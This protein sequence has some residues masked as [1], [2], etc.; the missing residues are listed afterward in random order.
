MT[1]G[2]NKLIAMLLIAFICGGH[3]RQIR[4]NRYETQVEDDNPIT[5][6]ATVREIK[7]TP[8]P[9]AGYRPGRAFDLPGEN[10]DSAGI[11]TTTADGLADDDGSGLAT[12]TTETAIDLS[13]TT[14]TVDLE[15]VTLYNGVPLE[16][17][18]DDDNEVIV[19]KK[20]PYPAAGFKPKIAFNLPTENQVVEEEVVIPAELPIPKKAPYPAAGYR[21]S[22]AF[23]L[24]TEVTAESQVDASNKGHPVCGVSTNPLA[25]KPAEGTEE[26]PDSET[27]VVTADV[28]PV[29]ITAPVPRIIPVNVNNAVQIRSQPIM[30]QPLVIGRPFAY[31]A[32]W[33]TW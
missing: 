33:Q 14:S 11:T 12:T 9:A 21:P 6:N 18:N 7:P 30:A 16:L 1:G 17:N 25:P 27:V 29:V 31:S 20:A 15:T 4:I 10:A 2:V 8:Y 26:N 23:L 13:T 3:A 24:P 19:A 5:V 32:Q 22:R 28:G